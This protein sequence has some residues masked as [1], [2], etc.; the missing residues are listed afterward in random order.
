VVIVQTPKDADIYKAIVQ[1]PKDADIY[2]PY[3]LIF[4]KKSKIQ[5]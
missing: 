4:T 1:T 2:K 3:K 5:A